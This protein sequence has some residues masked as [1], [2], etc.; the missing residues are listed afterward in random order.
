M[1]QGVLYSLAAVLP[2]PEASRF[3]SRLCLKNS[4]WLSVKLWKVAR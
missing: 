1:T 2:D 4:N 3:A